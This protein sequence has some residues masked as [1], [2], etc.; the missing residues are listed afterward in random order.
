MVPQGETHQVGLGP[1]CPD[2]THPVPQK[3][4]VEGWDGEQRHDDKD[5]HQFGAEEEEEVGPRAVLLEILGVHEERNL[6]IVVVLIRLSLPEFLRFL[7][8]GWKK[9][10][11]N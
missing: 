6:L 8:G 9:P 2:G 4:S 11:I 5:L 7:P 3:I 10:V 1:A